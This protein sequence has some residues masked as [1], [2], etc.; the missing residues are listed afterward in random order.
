M[1][2]PDDSGPGVATLGSGVRRFRRAVR[3]IFLE[4]GEFSEEY[5]LHIEEQ[6]GGEFYH[7]TL[8]HKRHHQREGSQYGR[9][10]W[11]GTG[12]RLAQARRQTSANVRNGWSRT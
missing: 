5:D 4:T 3:S 2:T 11:W 12:H 1:P 10:E 7:V 8:A 6:A 9:P